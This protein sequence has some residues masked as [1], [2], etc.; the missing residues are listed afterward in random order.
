MRVVAAVNYLSI[1]SVGVRGV[2]LA[3]LREWVTTMSRVGESRMSLGRVPEGGGCHAESSITK[4][5]EIS[6][7]CGEASL[8]CGP[9]SSACGRLVEEIREVLGG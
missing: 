8:S 6:S 3:P 5:P 9:Q 2:A 4:G 7:W 1:Q